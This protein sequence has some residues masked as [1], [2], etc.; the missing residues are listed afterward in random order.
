MKKIKRKQNGYEVPQYINKQGY[1]VVDLE[2]KYG[3]VTKGLRVDKL[4]YETFKRKL[5]ED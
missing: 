4:V 5:R 3:N 1:S 2:D